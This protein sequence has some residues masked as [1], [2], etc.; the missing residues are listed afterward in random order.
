MFKR[1]SMDTGGPVRKKHTVLKLAGSMLVA[2]ALFMVLVSIEKNMLSDFEKAEVVLCKE[3]VPTGT[4]I[5]KDN[6][7]QYFY[8]REIDAVL[9]DESCL[10]DMDELTDTVINNRLSAQEIV[11]NNDYSKEEAVYKRY[12]DPVEGSFVGNAGSMVSG[13]IRKGDQI[14]IAVVNKD[15]LEYVI[16]LSDVYV[17]DAF[18]SNGEK[19]SPDAAG[20]VATML[21]IVEEK[22]NL[23]KFYSAMELGE[24]IVTKTALVQ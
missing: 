1:K 22:D 6:V 24:V 21:T 15:T 13:T 3:T 23:A 12:R 20:I 14:D 10:T 5:T 4:E 2:F 19:I 18:T 7:K 8:I 17:M 11:R 16:Q 9:V